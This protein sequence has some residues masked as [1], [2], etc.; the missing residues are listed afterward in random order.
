MDCSTPGFS[1]LH[2]LL[3][4]AQTHVHWIGDAT[5]PPSLRPLLLP[6]IFPSIRIFSH[7]QSFPASG[8]FPMS[9]LFTA[10]SQS[11]GASALALVLP[12]NI[13]GWFPLGLAGLILHSKGLSRVFSSTTVWSHQFFGAQPS[14]GFPDGSNSK[15][16]TYNV[17][18]LGLIPGLG[19]SPGEGKGYPLLLIIVLIPTSSSLAWIIPCTMEPG[20]P[21]PL[22]SQRVGQH[23][24]TFTSLQHFL[25]PSPHICMWLLEKR[26]LW[27]DGLLVVK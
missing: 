4:F 15:E 27:L 11:I 22:E 6:S 26:W 3:E 2:Y 7:L 8:S 13:N 10:G 5:Q 16:S 25:W 18:Y 24:V 14:L 20:R 21:Q 12:V 19:R 9:Q 23:W 1:V 17:G